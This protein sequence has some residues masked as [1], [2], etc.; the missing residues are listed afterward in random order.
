MKYI[1]F[2]CLFL[3]NICFADDVQIEVEPKEPIMG[4]SFNVTFK[5]VT[6][7]G[8]DPI[9]SFNPQ[10]L[11]VLSKQETGISTRTTYMNGH[12]T[13][14]RSISI[15]YEMIANRSGSVYLRDIMIDVNGNKF[16]HKPYRI[17]IL[18]Q[19]RRAKDILAVA[20]VDKNEA[21]VGESILVRYYLYN[22]IQV[23]STDIK[24]FPKL[25][26]FLK[27]FHQE[28]MRAER[29][30]LDGEI[31]TRRVI[32]TAQLFANTPGKYKL[33]PITLNVQ[34]LQR[35]SRQNSFGFGMQKTSSKTISSKPIEIDI[36]QLPIENVP[37]YFTGLVGK[38]NFTLSINKNKFVVNEPIE[39]KFSVSGIG[40]LEIF[41]APKLI[42][43]PVLEE[44]DTNS[45]FV[46]NSDF[47]AT[48]NFN[49]T[50]LGRE[51]F[52]EDSKKIP[53]AYF[54]P[55]TAQYVTINLDLGAVTVAGG[56]QVVQSH[57]NNSIP[58]QTPETAKVVE[59][60]TDLTP[61]Y[62][63]VNNYL[64]NKK[65]ILIL[66]S[67]IFL[68]LIGIKLFNFLQKMKQFKLPYIKE[69]EKNGFNYG[70]LHHLL[71]EVG[72]GVD[73]R[74]IVT[75]S[76][77]SNKA[78]QYF[79]KLINLCEND[80]KDASKNKVHK[81]NKKYLKEAFNIIKEKNEIY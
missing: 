7:N 4:E 72:D 40:A 74:E 62:T 42:K 26:K 14:E 52:S 32:Y 1:I 19:A 73:M 21:F 10:G 43:N 41:E 24:K 9:I 5:V 29:V 69:I 11:E 49:L 45:D 34:Y 12:L 67:L 66:L 16:G 57:G 31:Y 44:F 27:R 37:P 61:A 71:S 51:P 23:S 64:Y 65:Y 60:K 50:Y 13:V 48:K 47:S 56:V 30:Q 8:T 78:K 58:V 80:Y 17:G 68:G 28:T 25:D 63:L 81:A 15:V 22:K 18:K 2:L 35:S 3:T 76:Q 79:L 6:E 53:F 33:D 59:T 38:H 70:R 36:K 55:E 75:Q 46:I 20:V 39:L 77:L 54:D